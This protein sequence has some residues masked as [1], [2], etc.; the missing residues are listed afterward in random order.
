MRLILTASF[1]G[2]LARFVVLQFKHSSPIYASND[3]VA[4]FILT[5]VPL[6][7]GQHTCECLT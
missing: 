1:T 3:C 7:S 4:T 6:Q 2:R 5:L